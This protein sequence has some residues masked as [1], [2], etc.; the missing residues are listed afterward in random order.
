MKWASFLADGRA[1]FGPVRDGGVADVSGAM[2]G[3]GSLRAALAADALP[4]LGTA[5]GPIL[6]LDRVTLLPPIP[7]PAKIICVGLNYHS[8]AAEVGAT[9]PRHPA[10]FARFANSVVGHDVAVVAPS[11]SEQF[12]YEGELA[13]VIGRAARH[14]AAAD[15]LSVVAGYACF[16]ENSVRDV[17]RHAATATAGKNF[18]RSGAWGP[19]LV[20]PD[21]AG[22]PGRLRLRTMLNGTVVQQGSTAD[23]IFSVPELIAYVTAFTELEPGDVLVT[24]TPPGVGSARTPP[25]WM[26]PGDRLTIEIENVGVLSNTVVAEDWAQGKPE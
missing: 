23:M 24:G 22:D 11:I 7:D 18:H 14:V 26:R 4:A 19:F 5:P 9:V 15:A 8:H 25:L 6:P 21:L 10:L 17:Q 1:G 2:P 20:T 12:D 16:A 3:I 13:V